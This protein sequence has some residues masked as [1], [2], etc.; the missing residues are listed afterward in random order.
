MGH[1]FLL[2]KQKHELLMRQMVEEINRGS[3]SIEQAMA[4]YKVLTRL[5]VTKWIDKIRMEEST[6]NQHEKHAFSVPPKTIVEQITDY[7]E[8]QAAKVKELEKALE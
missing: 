8:E 4:K 2:R 1:L 5:I 6:R 3:L 7:A